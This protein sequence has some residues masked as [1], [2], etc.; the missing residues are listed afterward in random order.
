[1]R[2]LNLIVTMIF[3]ELF[4]F[5][6]WS[7]E[8]DVSNGGTYH[9]LF[10]STDNPPYELKAKVRQGKRIVCPY[11]DNN[12]WSAPREG[13]QSTTVCQQMPTTTAF[14]VV[15]HGNVTT[16]D[17]NGD[18][19]EQEIVFIIYGD[20]ED[21]YSII[22]KEIVCFID[23]TKNVQQNF[24][25]KK[26]AENTSVNW[27][28]SSPWSGYQQKTGVSVSVGTEDSDWQPDIGS[29]DVSIYENEQSLQTLASANLLIAGYSVIADGVELMKVTPENTRY[30]FISANCSMPQ[31]TVK[32]MPDNLSGT[33]TYS[34]VISY[35]RSGRNDVSTF[36]SGEIQANQSWDITHAL[37]NQFLGGKAVLTCNYN[38]ISQNLTFYIRGR[39]P[40]KAAAT[41]YIEAHSTH[42]YSKYVAIHESDS[43]SFSVMQQFNESGDTIFNR[44][45][46]DVRYTPNAS[47]DGGFGI[48]QL[49]NPVPTINQLWSWKANCD[50]G[51]SR[52]NS[53]QIYADNWMNA[54]VGTNGFPRGG[55]RVQAR[56]ANNGEDVPVPTKTY[57]NVTFCDGTSIIIEHA[58]ALKRYNG[59]GGGNFC[60]WN[61][62]LS[63]W[64]FNENNNLGFN[65]VSRICSEVP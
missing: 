18:G 63:K 15:F 44:G 27:R 64:Q 11:V 43:A 13:K 42:W 5:H 4:I 1:M 58:V 8:F 9:K 2:K 57:G 38:G 49:T 3:L 34:L 14:S 46:S 16:T 33:V 55:Q 25:A 41:A 50:E 19:E 52:L 10:Q 60:S 26:G 39:N 40:T 32:M 28:V 45:D 30:A 56:N 23:Q 12:S 37:N 21:N 62:T 47:S 53:A 17:G 61:N 35:N 36:N 20:Y 6:M 48:F 65:Y 7:A 31:L 29:Y 59:A 22:P 54:Q 24:T 51:I